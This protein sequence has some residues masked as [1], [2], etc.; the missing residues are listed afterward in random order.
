M[1]SRAEESGEEGREQ[2]DTSYMGQSKNSLSLVAGNGTTASAS[3]GSTVTAL[4]GTVL[5]NPNALAP[6]R[7]KFIFHYGSIIH[8]FN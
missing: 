7:P 5:K 1:S 3:P 2:T 6:Q 4:Y 8:Q